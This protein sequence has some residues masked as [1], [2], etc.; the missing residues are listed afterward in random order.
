MSGP[1]TVGALIKRMR[2]TLG[3][4][5]AR[6]RETMLEACEAL[7]E[8]S[9]RLYEAEHPKVPPPVPFALRHDSCEEGGS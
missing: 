1:T 3:H 4:L 5:S 7:L 2:K 6:D 8:M 9:T